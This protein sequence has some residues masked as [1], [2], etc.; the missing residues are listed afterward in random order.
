MEY[1]N[2]KTGSQPDS[3]FELRAGY[4]KMIL[5]GMGQGKIPGEKGNW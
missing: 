5:P 2:I 4:N 1:K 3:L